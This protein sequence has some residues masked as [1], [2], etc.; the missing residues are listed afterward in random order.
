[1]WEYVDQKISKYGHF[2]H[3][4]FLY[5]LIT[6]FIKSI[7]SFSTAFIV[8]FLSIDSVVSLLLLFLKF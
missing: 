2:L 3:S 5:L 7:A 1:M 4:D 8:F 6:Y